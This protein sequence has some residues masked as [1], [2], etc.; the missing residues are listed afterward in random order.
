MCDTEKTAYFV[1]LF[2]NPHVKI[3]AMQHNFIDPRSRKAYLEEAQSLLDETD[4][5]VFRAGTVSLLN[6]SAQ[7]IN[8]SAEY[9]LRYN[10]E[11]LAASVR[12]CEKIAEF[13]QNE[14]FAII[15]F[16]NDSA[17]HRIPL[18]KIIPENGNK[19][20]IQC[21]TPVAPSFFIRSE[22]EA[23]YLVSLL[24]KSDIPVDAVEGCDAKAELSCRFLKSMGIQKRYIKKILVQGNLQPDR[25]DKTLPLISW[26][27]HIAPLVET[28][29][30][31]S[32]VIDLF[33]SKT[34][35]LSISQWTLLTSDITNSPRVQVINSNY[36]YDA[37]KKRVVLVTPEILEDQI[38]SLSFYEFTT[39]LKQDGLFNRIICQKIPP[40]LPYRTEESSGICKIS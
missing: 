14:R 31:N 25:E 19:E 21:A 3:I 10:K 24:A 40:T 26:R 8:L 9:P 11:P 32:Y 15:G 39:G 13:A 33:F 2:F 28:K 17:G 18:L 5:R 22:R 4:P 1:L 27:W 23:N 38:K 16:E 29:D 12:I 30:G 34:Q 36:T 37:L 35:A 20:F 7:A 6:R